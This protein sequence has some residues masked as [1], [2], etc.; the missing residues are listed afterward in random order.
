MNRQISRTRV[1]IAERIRE[2]PMNAA[3]RDAALD[4]FV[5]AERTV[6]ALANTI[7]ALRRVVNGATPV[8]HASSFAPMS[9]SRIATP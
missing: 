8:K 6:N 2:M 4:C 7:E 3:D 9:S 1:S 5:A